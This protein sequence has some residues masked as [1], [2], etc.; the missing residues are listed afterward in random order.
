MPPSITGAYSHVFVKKDEVQRQTVGAQRHH[1]LARRK[2][3][4]AL[5]APQITGNNTS[6]AYL[7]DINGGNTS[8][9]VRIKLHK[10][11]K[12]AWVG[13][14]RLPSSSHWLRAFLVTT[15]NHL[16][17]Y[18]PFFFS[19][20]YCNFFSCKPSKGKSKF[21]LRAA[22]CDCSLSWAWAVGHRGTEGTCPINTFQSMVFSL[23]KE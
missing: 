20:N 6:K 21:W 10:I 8:I 3:I 7:P 16:Y 15:A 4:V 18:I 5:N 19:R 23:K 17:K 1:E 22:R 9:I 13:G 11:P 14:G 2:K 12:Y